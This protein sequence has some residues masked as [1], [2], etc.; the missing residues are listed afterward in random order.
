M[1]MPSCTRRGGKCGWKLAL[2]AALLLAAMHRFGSMRAYVWS[3][4]SACWNSGSWEMALALTSPLVRSAAGFYEKG[5]NVQDLK[6]KK[7]F[8]ER[9]LESDHLWAVEFYREVRRLARPSMREAPFPEPCPYPRDVDTA[10]C[11]RPSG[12]K[13]PRTSR[14]VHQGEERI[15]GR[16]PAREAMGDV[17]LREKSLCSPVLPC[18]RRT[19]RTWPN[20]GRL[21]G[22]ARL[23]ASGAPRWSEHRDC[24]RTF[25]GSCRPFQPHQRGA[26]PQTLHSDRRQGQTKGSST[27]LEE[28]RQKW[29]SPLCDGG[30][31][32]TYRSCQ[33][34][35]ASTSRFS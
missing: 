32:L 23:A 26:N 5:S 27:Y 11:S 16:S 19:T 4:V 25:I 15:L 34:A 24:T 13:S 12:R 33:S 18:G 10:S 35:S 21:T 28:S 29:P 7:E 6:S 9:V 2:Y 1:M 22:G 20:T 31:L 30:F 17:S 3:R 14:C 8:R